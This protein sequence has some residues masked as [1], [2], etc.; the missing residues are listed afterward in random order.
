[1]D[2]NITGYSKLASLGAIKHTEFSKVWS[3]VFVDESADER[4]NYSLL[5]AL[6]TG[7]H[8]GPLRMTLKFTGVRSLKLRDF[9]GSPTQ[10][11]GFSID[12]ISSRQWEDIKYRVYD[13]E[14]GAIEFICTN[15]EIVEVVNVEQ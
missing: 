3:M 12:D 14:Y 13:Q 9:G 5:L 2:T 11:L 4:S 10:I 7:I 8:R 1:M 6:E 15:A